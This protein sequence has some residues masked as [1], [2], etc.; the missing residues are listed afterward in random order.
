[1]IG[2]ITG[3]LKTQSEQQ[4]LIDVH[5]IGYEVDVPAS[6][7]MSGLAAGSEI[8]LHTHFVVREDAQILFGFL[9]QASRDLFR[10]LIKVNKVGPRIALAILSHL[11]ANAFA[12]C[13]R[14]SDIKT[15]NAIPGVGRVMAERLVMELSGRLDDLI[16]VTESQHERLKSSPPS[17]L[18]DELEGALVGLGFRPQEI[19]LALSQLEPPPDNIEDGLRRALKLLG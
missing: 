8:S 14:R 10:A 6:V 9:D 13:V 16:P 2:Q 19:A 7:L 3:I 15:L 11:D 5:G 18:M 4:L 17:H 1:V 12:A